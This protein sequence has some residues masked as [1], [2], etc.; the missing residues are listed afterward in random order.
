MET[1]IDQVFWLWVPLSLL[2]V[3]LRIALVTYFVIII[4]RPILVRLLPKLIEW[5][6]IIL[7]K[8]I[9]LVSYPIMNWFHTF[10]TKRRNAGNYVIPS[11]IEFIEDTFAVLI[12][13]FGKTEQLAQ[14]RP[15]R[16]K[17][18]LKKTFRIAAFILAILLPI[19]IV[20][21]PTQAYAQTWHKFDKWATEEK[22]QK[23]LG[24]DLNGLQSKLVATV[25]SVNPTEFTLKEQYEEG[26]NIRDTPSLNGNIVESIKA[27]ETVTYL[28]EESIDDRGITWLKVET[29]SGKEGWI[30]QKIV[31][32]T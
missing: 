20:N 24:F 30:S 29:D 26:G 18:H 19:A 4:S 3:W 16:H 7:K 31:E 13:G 9:E 8:A 15:T 28:E 12:K 21:N 1:I 5:L 2:P 25:E 11:W 22:V 32:E 10:L 14:K 6:S 23:S 27:G 17:A